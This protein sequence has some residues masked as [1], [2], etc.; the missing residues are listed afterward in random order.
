MFIPLPR[1]SKNH[2]KWLLCILR[3]KHDAGEIGKIYQ[4]IITLALWR[5]LKVGYSCFS[6]HYIQKDVNPGRELTASTQTQSKTK[7]HLSI[8]DAIGLN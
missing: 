6:Y 4:F 2:Y 8:Y 5:S 1:I 7:E 3:R